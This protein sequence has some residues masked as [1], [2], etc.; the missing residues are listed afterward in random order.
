MATDTFYIAGMTCAGCESIIVDQVSQ[1]SGA[2]KAQADYRRGT[3]V[4]EFDE[5]SL[6]ADKIRKTIISCGYR[7]KEN[8]PRRSLLKAFAILLIVVGLYW[9]AGQLGIFTFFSN[10]PVAEQSTTIGVIFLIG[11]LTSVH[12]VSMCGGINLSQSISGYSPSRSRLSSLKPNLLYNSARLL[13]YTVIGGCIGGLG[14]LLD[15]SD[16]ARAVI[17]I[18]AGMFVVLMGLRMLGVLPVA[19]FLDAFTFTRTLSSKITAS[20]Y[21]KG[22]FVVGLLNGFMPCGPLQAM[23][24]Y[25]LSTGSILLGSLSLFLFG[26][27]T[28]P[29]MV[30]LGAI[31]MALKRNHLAKVMTVG[32]FLVVLMGV[33]MFSNGLVAS[34]VS[35]PFAGAVHEAVVHDDV[36]QITTQLE[37]GSHP[38]ISVKAGIPVQWTIEAE[39]EHINGCNNRFVSSDFNINHSFVAGTNTIAFTPTEP[40][41]YA[42]SCWMNMIHGTITVT[43]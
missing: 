33:G 6:S 4:V 36:Q 15:F 5:R 41:V 9:M 16:Q 1:L 26:L 24:L 31:G 7:I 3:L 12:C 25:A 43:E 38:A 11:L 29:L 39:S 10:F 19:T 21:D 17:Q 35:N 37:S 30:G 13:S 27:G 18:V 34:G 14:S 40:G 23:Q 20:Y 28:I 42:Y 2:T 8:D 22:P 32:A